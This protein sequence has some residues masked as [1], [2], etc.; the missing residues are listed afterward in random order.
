[1]VE[2]S[3]SGSGEGP[4]WVTAPGYS[5][6]PTI[7]RFISRDPLITNRLTKARRGRASLLPVL[8]GLTGNLY[9]YVKNMPNNAVDP[10]GEVIGIDDLAG[11]AA[12][13]WFIAT[14]GQAL[15]QEA[16][17]MS[18][19]VE[20]SPELAG[21]A[22]QLGEMWG[23]RILSVLRNTKDVAGTYCEVIG[24]KVPQIAANMQGRVLDILIK[25][26]QQAI[27]IEAKWNT[28][29]YTAPQREFD[30]NAEEQITLV[31]RGILNAIEGEVDIYLGGK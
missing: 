19:E 3:K 26:E 11:Y 12:L 20:S 14:Y 9:L 8:G 6:D 16:Q 10:N 18:A 4:G 24:T 1:M 15:E 27:N 21:D 17:D 25:V 7:Q 31:V 5:T 2:I 13:A 22:Y 23:D 28:S 29:S 30:Q